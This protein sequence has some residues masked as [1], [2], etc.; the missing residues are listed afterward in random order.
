MNRQSR[1]LCLGWREIGGKKEVRDS[2]S[3]FQTRVQMWVRRPTNTWIHIA[4]EFETFQIL[5]M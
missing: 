3:L 5:E 1:V 2:V 4:L